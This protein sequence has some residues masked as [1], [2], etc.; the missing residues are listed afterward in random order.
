[1]DGAVQSGK[2]AAAEVISR[3]EGRDIELHKTETDTVPK[4][5]GYVTSL[6]RWFNRFI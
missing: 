1:M 5:Y 4:Y 2:R 3:L 6:K